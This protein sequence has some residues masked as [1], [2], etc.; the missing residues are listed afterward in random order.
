MLY[1]FELFSNIY[2]YIGSNEI[3]NE[4][5]DKIVCVLKKK[6]KEGVMFFWRENHI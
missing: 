2:L 4:T 6:K 1:H 5:L 3:S